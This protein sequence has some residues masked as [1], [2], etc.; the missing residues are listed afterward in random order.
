M[1]VVFIVIVGRCRRPL[2]LLVLLLLSS[3]LRL[4]CCTWLLIG[5]A[6]VVIT[7]LAPKRYA[8]SSLLTHTISSFWRGAQVWQDL[9]SQDLSRHLAN[10]VATIKEKSLDRTSENFSV[11]TNCFSLF[12]SFFH[13]SIASEC[14][15]LLL[16]WINSCIEL[17]N[18]FNHNSL[19]QKRYHCSYNQFDLFIVSFTSL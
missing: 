17:R 15:L 19:Q 16:V 8:A 13:E 11:P 14:N 7:R 6:V 9:P 12:V 4:C 3:L 18:C 2:V 10:F 5:G 1:L